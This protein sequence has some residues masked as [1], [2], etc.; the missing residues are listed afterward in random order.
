MRVDGVGPRPCEFAVVGEG[1]GFHEA[2]CGSPFV[3]KTGQELDRYLNGIDLPTRDEVFLTNVFRTYEGKDYRYTQADLER[4]EPCLLKELSEVRPVTIIT[5]GRYATRFFLGDTDMDACWGI[6]WVLWVCYGCMGNGRK[7]L[8]T[9]YQNGRLLGVDGV[10]EQE[11]I[12]LVDVSLPNVVSTS[13]SIHAHQGSSTS[14]SGSHLS[15]Q[16]VC[17]TR[18]SGTSNEGREQS[19]SSSCPDDVSEWAPLGAGDNVSLSGDRASTL[20]DMRQSEREDSCGCPS[21]GASLDVVTCYPIHHPAAA[22]HNPEMSPYVV[23]GFQQLASYLRGDLQPRRLFDD[24]IKAPTYREISTEAELEEAL[25]GIPEGGTISID[26]EGYPHRPWSLQFSFTPGQAYLLRAGG[27]PLR[28]FVQ[29]V[30]QDRRVFR[31]CYHSSLHELQMFRAMGVP[32]LNDLPFDDTMVMS[33]LLQLTPQGLKPSC[34]RFCNMAMD[35]YSDIMGDVEDRLTRDY[36]TWIYDV[37][38][39]DYELAQVA[40]LLRLQTTPY[41]D[42]KGKVHG[43]RRV[44]KLPALPRSQLQK[45]CGRVMQS[46]RPRKLWDDQVLDVHVAAYDRLRDCPDATLDYVPPSKAIH[47]GCRDADGTTRLLPEYSQRLD[48]M[49]L[50]AVYNLELSTYPFIDRMQHIGLK[51]DLQHFAN[52]SRKLAGEISTLQG[53]LDVEVGREGL[54]ANSGD[55]VAEY[56][57]NTLGL[58]S[59]KQTSSGRGST[60]DKI[61]E[62]LEHEHPEYP[63]I[64]TIRSFRETYKLKNTFVDRL[65]DFA[66]R[67]PRDGRI[68]S[69]FRTTRVV[70]GRLAASD[71][72][73]L[74]MP[75][76]GKFAKEFRR[77]WV[78]EC[79]HILGSWDLSQIELRIA[80]HLSQ[81]PIMLATYRGERRNP[82][83]SMIDLHAALAERIFGVKPNL[84][85]DSKH[86]LPAKAINFGFWMGQTAKGL[87]VELLKNGMKV[88]EDDAQRWL[89]EAH[90][91]YKGARPYMEERAAEA[92]RNGYIRCMGGRIR[93][94]G[95]IRSPHERTRE[96]AERFAFSTPIQAGAQTVM[97]TNEARIW[98]DVI[99]PLQRE[100]YWIEP[101]VQIHD[102]IVL[103]MQ[104]DIVKTVAPMMVHCMTKSYEGLSVPIK[105]SSSAGYNWADMKEVQ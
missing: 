68:H 97:K 77:G 84:Q 62:A 14:R 40:E 103:E 78:P 35:S 56:L 4:D 79:G 6:P 34:L 44:T 43:G 98:N 33:Y 24:P 21:C 18:T 86:R 10:Y 94:I 48:A 47:Y 76:H 70:S 45:A 13:T 92:R 75:K 64:T 30:C 105:T 73:I 53:R 2:R 3:G 52:L 9:S 67:W 5:L 28:R 82:D 81:D 95:G 87:L 51:P 7:V 15:K 100:G 46:K 88:A 58:D 71:P 85:D 89:D 91:L 16:V 57:F 22:L 63:V 37:E 74:A 61:L 20:P 29:I 25:S 17:K 93:Y 54:N 104:D 99:V 27:E 32:E 19:S 90:S 72:N 8:G 102:D 12:R 96:E 80:A 55:Q 39:H 66:N 36:L 65:S 60:N 23:A 42:A 50:R 26:T 49:G 41:I 1:P 11:G 31:L 83:G 59:M 101:I 38:Q 69:T